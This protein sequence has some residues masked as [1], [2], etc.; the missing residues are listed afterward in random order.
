MCKK[1]FG[2]AL[3][4]RED[5]EVVRFSSQ[6]VKQVQL[7]ETEY[8]RCFACALSSDSSDSLREDSE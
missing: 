1:L 4:G 6:S 3:F 2:T 5:G 8:G 7:G